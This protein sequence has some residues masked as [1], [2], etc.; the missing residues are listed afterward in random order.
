M[1]DRKTPCRCG[2]PGCYRSDAAELTDDPDNDGT[3]AAHPAWWRGHDR[4]MGKACDALSAV[5]DLGLKGG[6]FAHP[7][8]D[9]LADRLL[10]VEAQGGG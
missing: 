9:A 5:L 1:T 8:L 7:K 3:D 10:G 2:F 6:K 4:A